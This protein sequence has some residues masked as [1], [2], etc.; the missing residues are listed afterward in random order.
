ML[1]SFELID[2][3]PNEL[4]GGQAQ[5]VLIARSLAVSPLLL[6]ADE[7]TSML[8]VSSQAEI[9]SIFTSLVKKEGISLLLISHD[10]ALLKSIYDRNYS[11]KEKKLIEERL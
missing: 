3:R 6:I 2:R 4:S 10:R 7:A 11:V 1:I 9:V 5:R 8:D